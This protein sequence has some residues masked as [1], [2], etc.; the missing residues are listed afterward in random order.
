MSDDRRMGIGL[1]SIHPQ[2]MLTLVQEAEE[3]GFYSVSVGDNVDDSFAV[4]AAMAAVTSRIKLI[5]SIAAW[6]RTPVTTARACRSMDLLSD[7][8]FIFGLGSMPR[9]W[10]EN[11][12]GIPGAAPLSRMREFV[13]LLRILWAATPDTPVNYEGRFYKV[14]GYRVH[15]P[16]PRPNIPIFIGASRPRM[17]RETG[18]WA[19]GILFN[20]NYTL[21]WLKETGKPALAEGAESAGRSVNDLE[22]FSGRRVFITDDPRQAEESRNAFR[23]NLAVTYLGVDYHQQLLRSFGFE[24]EVDA[25]AAALARS[26]FEGAAKAVSDRMVDT[27]TIIGPAD[28]CLERVSEYTSQVNCFTLSTPTEGMPRTERASAVRRLIQTFGR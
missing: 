21:P 7:G 23:H 27:F 6:T 26:D 15:E 13:E 28:E 9:A 11:F 25:A 2:D 18:R 19:D 20:W 17:V 4:L 3:A 16:P 5:S 8:R 22:I 10:N 12:H 1:A 24:E 14:S